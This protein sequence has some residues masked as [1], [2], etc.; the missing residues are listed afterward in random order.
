MILLLG[1]NSRK[2]N[3]RVD[4]K[5]SVFIEVKAFRSVAF[6]SN[7]KIPNLLKMSSPAP[8]SFPLSARTFVVRG[9][10]QYYI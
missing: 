3:L 7:G 5:N 6:N 9:N 8:G 4:Y 2:G 10:I 1:V